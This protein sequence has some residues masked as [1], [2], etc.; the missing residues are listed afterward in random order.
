[1]KVILQYIAP[2]IVQDMANTI[3]YTGASFVAGAVFL[4]SRKRKPVLKA[5][6]M[7]VAV[8]LLIPAASSVMNGFSYVSGRWMW[9]F[10]L[11]AT[12]V[13]VMEWDDLLAAQGQQIA[14]AFVCTAVY[15]AILCAISIFHMKASF[16]GTVFA[17]AAILTM[18]LSRRLPQK[19]EKW[20]IALTGIIFLNLAATT[21]LQV[22]G[23]IM[24]GFVPVGKAW[25]VV[26]STETEAVRRYREEGGEAA[27]GERV[28]ACQPTLYNATGL[29]GVPGT[30]YYWSIANGNVTDFQID[31][32]VNMK[33]GD[34][35]MY[36]GLDSRAYL[37]A[38]VSAGTYAAEEGENALVPYGYEDQG[39]VEVREGRKYRIYRN[40]AVLPLGFTYDRVFREEEAGTLNAVQ[41]QEFYMKAAG[42]EIPEGGSLTGGE[43]P[44]GMANP[45]GSPDFIKEDSQ[46]EESLKNEIPA[47]EL[48]SHEVPVSLENG[49]YIHI[50]EDGSIL[51]TKK[52]AELTIR[53]DSADENAERYLCIDGFEMQRMSE[54]ELYHGNYTA[55][56][57]MEKFQDLP[58]DKQA[59]LKQIYLS[60]DPDNRHHNTFTIPVTSGEVE[61]GFRYE[62]PRYI[63]YSGVHDFVLNLGY[64]ESLSD[65]IILT[66]PERGLYRFDSISVWQ[67]PLRQ[68]EDLLRER[69]ENVL[70]D[71]QIQ[72][73]RIT[74]SISLEK[75]KLLFLSIGY[76]KGWKAFVD[77]EEVPVYKTNGLGMGIML[78]EGEH[79]VE[80]RYRTRGILAGLVLSVLGLCCFILAG[81][82]AGVRVMKK[83][84]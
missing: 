1:M 76:D 4:A 83:K 72:G 67:Q 3:C 41:K 33:E 6:Y 36:N 50:Q 5:A 73:N 66:F 45:A 24:G 65:K 53:V 59:K 39:T 2:G 32:L 55:K 30:G 37:L 29:L 77:G 68:L 28:E 25:N 20:E 44:D 58:E 15:L 52:N 18:V 27:A 21:G 62:T 48:L 51:V 49:K 84:M 56:Y 43:S 42:I 78:K 19:K 23:S 69:R 40:P 47:E 16:L 17:G 12:L 13:L 46:K 64:G 34:Y 57:N 22:R 79:E 38:L 10:L 75:E 54:W 74:G 11:F 8:M 82:A 35:Q 31:L 80:L 14:W 61:T 63:W 7:S 9:L 70:E 71:V 60:Y 26:E 81:H